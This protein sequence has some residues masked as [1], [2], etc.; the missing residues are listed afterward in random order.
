MFCKSKNK[1]RYKAHDTLITLTQERLEG[2]RG[3][4]PRRRRIN[5]TP[6]S[7]S[8]AYDAL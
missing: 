4:E 8:E 5:N 6:R 1:S 2:I 3:E 7:G